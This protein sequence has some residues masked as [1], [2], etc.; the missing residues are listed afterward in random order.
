MAKKFWKSDQNV[1]VQPQNRKALIDALS[2]VT[3]GKC[4]VSG[5]NRSSVVPRTVYVNN[6]DPELLYY[7]KGLIRNTVYVSKIG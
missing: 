6:G 1:Y 2:L 5:M 7:L 3:F 4:K